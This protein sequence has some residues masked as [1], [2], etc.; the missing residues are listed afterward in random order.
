MSIGLANS[1]QVSPTELGDKP[2]EM[3]YTEGASYNIFYL[4]QN[5]HQI[6]IYRVLRCFAL[7]KINTKWK[8]WNGL[9]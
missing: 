9:D 2:R 8:S 1:I 3:E 5:K 7:Q 6:V 4:F